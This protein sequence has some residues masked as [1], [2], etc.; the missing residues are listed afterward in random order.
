M[1]I[2]IVGPRESNTNDLREIG[3]FLFESATHPRFSFKKTYVA[4]RAFDKPGKRALPIIPNSEMT[5]LQ[6]GPSRDGSY[7]VFWGGNSSKI[8]FTIA[9][10]NTCCVRRGSPTEPTLPYTNRCGK[11][12]ICRSCSSKN[13]WVFHIFLCF[14]LPRSLW[15]ISRKSGFS[16]VGTH[17]ISLTSK[18]GVLW[19]PYC[20]LSRW[21]NYN[22]S[23][24]FYNIYIYVYMYVCIYIYILY[25]CICICIYIHILYICICMYMYICIYIYI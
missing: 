12:T 25:I 21:V 15:Y 11:A 20:I 23:I 7:A 2:E 22:V 4:P 24:Y 10:A 9:T 17:H 19:V 8:A 5:R 18:M 16:D 1:V 14:F 13:P 3:R 6:T